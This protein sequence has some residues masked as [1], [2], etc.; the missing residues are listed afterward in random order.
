L[1]V[2]IGTYFR[3]ERANIRSARSLACRASAADRAA[4]SAAADAFA[5]ELRAASA[6]FCAARFALA[7]SD[8]AASAV[9]RT[10]SSAARSSGLSCAAHAANNTAGRTNATAD[11]AILFMGH[12]PLDDLLL[13][14][15]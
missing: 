10:C 1:Q 4:A 13:L 12:L 9:A 8:R 2:P 11:L 15:F 5:S 14:D 3:C 6:A 7:A